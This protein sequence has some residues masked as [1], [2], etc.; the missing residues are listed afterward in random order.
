MF[1]PVAERLIS[2]ADAF[3]KALHAWYDAYHRL[4]P[5]RDMPSLYKTVVSEFMLQQTQVDTVLPYFEKWMLRWPDF[6]ALAQATEEEVVKAWEG[7]GYYNRARNLYRLACL[8]AE[9]PEPPK[10]ADGWIVLPGVG[11]YT[12]AAIASIACGDPV[13]V[14]DGN[15]IRVLTRL[16]ADDRMFKDNGTAVK[17]MDPLAQALVSP[18]FPGDHNQAMMELGATICYRLKPLCTM[19]PVVNFCAGAADG[20]PERFPRFLPRITERVFLKRLWLIHDGKLLLRQHG[21]AAKRLSGMYELPLAEP[22]VA[23][24]LDEDIV[25]KKRRAIS[26]QQIEETIYQCRWMPVMEKVIAKDPELRWVQLS[27]LGGIT[28]SGPHRRWV[29]ELLARGVGEE[30]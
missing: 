13:A 4:L 10:T 24:L 3:H 16:V 23:I 15:V 26:N 25:A 14:V 12:A 30:M 29:N 22:L 11:P 19:C 17:A 8:V 6:Q 2:Q 27:D 5:W 9:M 28:L 20:D 7:L 21:A 18:V 1:S